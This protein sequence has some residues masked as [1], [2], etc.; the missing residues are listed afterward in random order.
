M[1]EPAVS[2]RVRVERRPNG[3]ERERYI[4]T[5]RGG[6][7][8]ADCGDYTDALRFF[9]RWAERYTEEDPCQSNN[10]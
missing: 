1:T 9:A 3:D 6:A 7:L 5:A 2:L 4:V 10:S 8:R